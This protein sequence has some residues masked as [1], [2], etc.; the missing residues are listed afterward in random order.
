[1]YTAIIIGQLLFSIGS[2]V[3]CLYLLF[4]TSPSQDLGIDTCKTISFDQFTQN[5]CQRTPLAKGVA[6][7]SFAIM[8]LVEIGTSM[9][10]SHVFAQLI[11]AIATIF[12]ANYFLSQVREEALHLE[13][14]DPKYGRDGYDC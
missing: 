6:V 8:W 12:V 11:P 2:G 1:L 7:A 9:L 14:V 3:V 13:I 10:W 4:Q 5:L